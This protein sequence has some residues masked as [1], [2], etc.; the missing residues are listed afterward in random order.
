MARSRSES[1]I[2]PSLALGPRPD[3]APHCPQ[4]QRKRRTLL[5]RWMPRSSVGWYRLAMAVTTRHEAGTT[6]LAQLGRQRVRLRPRRSCTIRSGVDEIVDIVQSAIRSPGRDREGHRVGATPSAPSAARR[7]I[8]V[9]ARPPDCGWSSELDP[10]SGRVTVG[11][12]TS[13]HDVEPVV[14]PAADEPSSTWVTSTPRPSPAPSPRGTHGTGMR[15]GGMATQVTGLE[16][17]TG[18]GT[19]VLVL[20]PTSTSEL[21]SAGTHPSR[22]PRHR[23]RRGARTLCHC[24]PWPP[25]RASMALDQLLAQWDEPGRRRRPF[26]GV[27]VS[28]YRDGLDQTQH[29]GRDRAAPPRFPVVAGLGGELVPAKHGLRRGRRDWAGASRSTIPMVNRDRGQGLGHPP[30]HRSLLPGVHHRAKSQIS[31]RWSTPCLAPSA[32][33]TIRTIDRR[34]S[35]VQGCAIAFPVE[36]R[37]AAGG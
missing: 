17:V 32:V 5:R 34:R 21:W 28:A 27:L 24:L 19:P 15:F 6:S 22:G 14:G 37:V 35:S 2:R 31:E 13:L 9:V 12:G 1:P 10:V 16:I 7:S 8:Q 18:D 20:H 26:R 4:G 25:R 3:Q 30:L 33:E 11:A 36:L 23:H 29:A